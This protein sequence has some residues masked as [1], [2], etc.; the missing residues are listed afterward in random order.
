M[1]KNKTMLVAGL[2]LTCVSWFAA[3]WHQAGFLSEHSFFPLWL[4]Y[5]LATNG[6][7]ELVYGESLIKRMGLSFLLLFLI[8]CPFWWFFESI[9]LIVQNWHYIFPH[10]ISNL[11]FQVEASINFSTVIPAVLSTSFLSLRVFRSLK[12]IRYTRRG[13]KVRRR[14]LAISVLFGG[15]SL[16]LLSDF[17]SVAFPLVWIAP[18]LILEPIAYSLHYPSML[19]RI[20]R[21]DWLLVTSVACGTLVNGFLWELWNFYSSP[22]WVY[23]IPYVGFWKIFEMPFLGY[24]GYPFFGLIVYSFTSFVFCAVFSRKPPRLD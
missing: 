5:I 17:P 14:W 1:N 4:G 13:F 8:S 2:T 21:G 9:N 20:E 24:F 16:W 7:S 19:H 12:V 6:I 3:W 18:L 15:V 11:A 10:P 22:K 23:T